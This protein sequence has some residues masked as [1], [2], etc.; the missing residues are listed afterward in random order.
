MFFFCRHPTTKKERQ[1]TK[2]HEVAKIRKSPLN[3]P[4]KGRLF[5]CGGGILCPCEKYCRV[6]RCK[7]LHLVRSCFSPA[8]AR[9]FRR[10]A[11]LAFAA[12][13]LRVMRTRKAP[14]DG[15]KSDNKAGVFAFSCRLHDD[16][17]ASVGSFKIVVLYMAERQYIEIKCKCFPINIEIFFHLCYNYINILLRHNVEGDI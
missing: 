6:L 15:K 14:W 17:K 9:F 5:G 8:A 12:H 4:F 2:E 16:A 7:V 11:A 13:S 10:V 1:N 3:L